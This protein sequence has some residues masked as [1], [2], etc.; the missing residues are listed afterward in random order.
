MP[1]FQIPHVHYELWVPAKWWTPEFAKGDSGRGGTFHDYCRWMGVYWRDRPLALL[2]HLRDMGG[3]GSLRGVAGL[4]GDAN[5]RERWAF[6]GVD[7]CVKTRPSGLHVV[8][9]DG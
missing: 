5:V 9:G 7:A 2:T 4:I 8:G 3:S 1:D 6:S